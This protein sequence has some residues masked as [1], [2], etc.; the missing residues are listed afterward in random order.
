M[1]FRPYNQNQTALF[2]YSFED[3]IP[4]KHP[5]RIIDHVVEA[6][7]PT[8]FKNIQKGRQSKLPSKDVVKSDA[9]CLYEQYLFES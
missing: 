9:I 2:P 3:L 1:N 7:Y 8:A 6:I 4:E 5:V